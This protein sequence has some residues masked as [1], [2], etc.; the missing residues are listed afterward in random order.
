MKNS[1]DRIRFITDYIFSYESKIKELNKQGL[2]NDA[3]MFEL[4][5]SKVGQLYLGLSKPLINLNIG[6]STYPCVDL[7]SEDGNIYCQV[8]TCQNVPAK[9]KTTLNNIKDS[10]RENI[11]KIKEVY[12][13]VLN[14]ESIDKVKDLTIGN[15]SFVKSKNLIT[16]S[17]IIEKAAND[18]SF[19][20]EL[21]ILLKKDD[22]LIKC[23]FKKYQESID[24]ESKGILEDI[25]EYI[26]NTYHIDLSDQINEIESKNSKFILVSGEAGSG[27]SV[28][29]KKLLEDKKNVLC[30]RAEK[31]V[32]KGDVNKIW[33]F[34]VKETLSLVKDEVYIYIDALEFIADNKNRL[35]VLNSLLMRIEELDNVHFLCSCRSSDLGSFIKVV[36]KYHIVEYK[37]KPIS[38]EILSDI[39]GK[40]KVLSEIIKNTK[41]DSLLTTPFYINFLTKL[42]FFS[43]IK[44]ENQLRRKIWEEIIC[45]NDLTIKPIIERIVL[46]RATKFTLYSDTSKYEKGIINRLIS[47]NVLIKND[48][49]IRLKYDIFEDI[50]F[51]QYIDNLFDES[52]SDYPSFFK[53]L[54]DVG[55]CIYRRYQIWIENKL[56]SKTNRQKFLYTL[57]FTDTIPFVWNQ[58]SIIGIIKSNYCQDFFN[59]YSIQIVNSDLLIKFIDIVN[60]YGFEIN[61][62]SFEVGTFILKNKGFGRESLIKIIYEQ[63]I[64]KKDFKNVGSIKKLIFDYTN[65]ISSKE[66]SQY[67]FEILKFY[68][69]KEL[70][71]DYSYNPIQ[72]EFDAI[73]KLHESADCW[74]KEYF[75]NL[76][77]FIDGDD[78]EKYDFA[79]DAIKDIL[80]S[81]GICLLKNYSKLIRELYTF[82]YTA[83]K[84][85]KNPFYNHYHDELSRNI[86]FGLNDNADTY[87]HE[88]FNQNPKYYNIV[89]ALLRTSFWPTFEWYLDFI[90]N[91]ISTFKEKNKLNTYKIYFSKDS[92]KE[93]L[94]IAGML[95]TGEIQNNI[96]ALI[97]DMTYIVKC[98]IID[99]IKGLDNNSREEFANSIKRLV[100]EKT[101]N[102]IGL[103][104]ISNIGLTFFKELPGYCLELVSSLEFVLDDLSRYSQLLY[105]PTRKM[106]E[107]EIALKV[108]LPDLSMDRYK[109]VSPNNELRKYAFLTQLNYPYL[110][111]KFFE[112]FDYLYSVLN[113]DEEHALLYL[114]L[115]QMDIRNASVK[116]VDDYTLAIVSNVNGAAKGIV[117]NAD[118]QNNSFSVVSDE[119]KKVS[120]AL[121]DKTITTK[122]IDDFIEVVLAHD[123]DPLS[124][125]FNNILIGCISFA[126][127]KL[128][129]DTMKRN[130]YCLIWLKY[131]KRQ[132][133]N[134]SIIIEANLYQF[135]FNQLNE[136]IDETIKKEIKLI[137][138]D[139]LINKNTS[140]GSIYKIFNCARTFICSEKKYSSLYL[141]TIFLLAEDEMEHQKYNYR[142]L[143][144]YHKREK[145]DFIPNM[146]PRLN[147]V[148]YYIKQDGRKLFKSKKDAIIKKYLIDEQGYDYSNFDIKKLDIKIISHTFSCG[149]D[150]QKKSDR[151]FIDNYLKQLIDIYSKKSYNAHDIISFYEIIEVENYFRSKLL[152]KNLYSL[153][154]DIIF[155]NVDFQKFTT[156]TIDFYLNILASLTAFYFDSYD[157]KEKRV[158]VEHVIRLLER[159]IN[160]IQVEYVKTELSRALFLGFDKFGGRGDW[161]EF[162][163]NYEYS[164]KVFLN[165]MFSKY[166]HLHFYD[167]LVVIYHLQYKKLLPE[168]LI[169]LHTSFKKYC[170]SMNRH[171]SDMEKTIGFINQIMYFAYVNFES[172]IKNDKELISSFEGILCLLIE[173]KDEKSAVL[174]DEFRIH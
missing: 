59:E 144:K 24:Y 68:I 133:N 142:Y 85:N 1:A 12:F 3:K 21:Y 69:E 155:D 151:L 154:I 52:K 55:R 140:D 11:K 146:Q 96:P 9:I 93:Y 45:L 125:Q 77:Q 22:E 163:T 113:N 91:C 57:I 132:L 47:N 42:K 102:I 63:E 40:V 37:I 104:I 90:N 166:G 158:H 147:G 170:E 174:L 101:N 89:F 150:P 138:L 128:K 116:E 87:E 162:K 159:Y 2:F 75:E 70:E 33:N 5:A 156:E 51:E 100:Y 148:D 29:C 27:K 53:K 107:N 112:I 39:S 149:L 56:F 67:S 48:N 129:I 16:T 92:T 135:L 105:S 61:D 110:K 95:E 119:V 8:S 26:N 49:G 10:A 121:K 161:S 160:N 32:E 122:D 164:D 71:E 38:K 44:D 143:C 72:K 86:L 115:Q 7:F 78:E 66:V 153:I 83:K 98:T 165:E 136:V 34:N 139:L 18:L 171:I 134:E 97:S 118:E 80:S 23:D 73:Y 82:Y 172:E 157:S 108:G 25:D 94:G 168:I 4:F 106:L 30:A 65:S 28:L 74:L 169:S 109:D 103:S 84:V 64:Y 46:E 13:I 117:D 123:S 79:N 6:T 15:V 152:D 17:N 173:S 54:E 111:N 145:E 14:N 58:Q 50:C 20:D 124:F 35:D 127:S 126:L 60:I 19:Q 131:A 36:G 41:Y 137:I 114:Q 141:N 81:N 31:I 130:E 62:I 99:F 167:L 88:S 43:S 120:D 76:K